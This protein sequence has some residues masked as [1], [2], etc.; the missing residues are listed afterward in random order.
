MSSNLATGTR[1]QRQICDLSKPHPTGGIGFQ[2]ARWYGCA[3]L[4]RKEKDMTVLNT[5]LIIGVIIFIA[6]E[7]WKEKRKMKKLSQ[8]MM[9]YYDS[10][11]VDEN[12]TRHFTY[13]P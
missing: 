10:E 3:N 13:T 1:R 6:V 7:R 5:A 8:K 4:L 2:L 9:D 11:W 12:G